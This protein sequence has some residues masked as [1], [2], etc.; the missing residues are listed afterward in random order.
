MRV[1][2][3]DTEKIKTLAAK[4]A[5]EEVKANKKKGILADC[6]NMWEKSFT[7]SLTKILQAL[8]GGRYLTRA[9]DVSK[10]G[11]SRKILMGFVENNQ[12]RPITIPTLLSEIGIDKRDRISGC[13]MDMCFEVQYRL[14][15]LLTDRSYHKMPGYRSLI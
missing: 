5:K 3:K 1:T 12:L 4:M 8:Y 11:M 2:K 7:A 9:C 15:H 6:D 14:W 10:S 13:G